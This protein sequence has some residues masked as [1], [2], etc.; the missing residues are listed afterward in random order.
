MTEVLDDYYLPVVRSETGPDYIADVGKLGWT[1]FREREETRMRD[2]N[3]DLAT[4]LEVFRHID[5]PYPAHHDLAGVTQLLSYGLLARQAELDRLSD[6]ASSSGRLPVVTM[7]SIDA[8]GPHDMS[9]EAWQLH[10]DSALDRAR[11]RNAFLTG[12]VGRY[13]NGIGAVQP[14]E[15]FVARSALMYTH[16]FL[17][18]Q[19]IRD[20]ESEG[21]GE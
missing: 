7:D 4:T 12:F 8:F 14:R 17:D 1:V 11:I 15:K 21:R 18:L 9:E 20:Y 16:A 2:E 10:C 5:S 13:L 6:P 19:S 3:S